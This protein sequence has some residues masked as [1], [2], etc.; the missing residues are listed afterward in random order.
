MQFIKL[1]LVICSLTFRLQT[2]VK[3]NYLKLFVFHYY[4]GKYCWVASLQTYAQMDIFF[5]T[6]LS[7]YQVFVCCF[8]QYC[9]IHVRTLSLCLTYYKVYSPP[10]RIYMLKTK[11]YH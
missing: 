7:Q 6:T 5:F 3:D 2:V 1:V 9:R 8:S 11:L 4:A 10:D